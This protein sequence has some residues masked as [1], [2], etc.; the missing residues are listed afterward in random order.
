MRKL[1]LN[2]SAFQKGEVLTRAQ[3]KKVSGG[4]GSGICHTPVICT[5]T[6]SN[7]YGD[8][9]KN[10]LCTRDEA[11]EYC[12]TMVAEGGGSCGYSCPC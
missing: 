1:T 3:M 2:A 4:T 12:L 9:Y 11:H 8:G 5:I 6:W 10:M 7:G